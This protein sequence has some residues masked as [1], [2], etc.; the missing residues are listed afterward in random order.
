MRPFKY[1]LTTYEAV[2]VDQVAAAQ[3]IT[4]LTAMTLTADTLDIPRPLTI[5]SAA[6]ES[7]NV[8]YIRGTGPKGQVQEEAVAGVDT[9]TA[10]SVLSWATI[11]EVIPQIAGSG[12]VSL[13]IA[14]EVPTP[15]YPLDYPGKEFVVSLK[16][17]VVGTLATGY[18]FETYEGKLSRGVHSGSKFDLIHPIDTSLAFDLMGGTPVKVSAV[19]N[20]VRP[21]TAV[22]L[23]CLEA[24]D[25]AESI[26]FEVLQGSG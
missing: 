8:F 22:R 23:V 15:W 13:G 1:V 12:N 5:V 9:G 7:D 18:R 20:L 2:D 6:D 26:T 14:T 19:Q 10:Q 16:A 3:A 4:A 25:A 17:T 24:L 21:C 11:T